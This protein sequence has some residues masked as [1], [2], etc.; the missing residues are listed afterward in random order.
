MLLI[1]EPERQ[2]RRDYIRELRAI[3]ASQPQYYISDAERAEMQ[4]RKLE[5]EALAARERMRRKEFI[6]SARARLA[7]YF[8]LESKRAEMRA[9]VERRRIARENREVRAWVRRKVYEDGLRYSQ[10]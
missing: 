6:Q 3:I 4:K 7:K 9:R 8:A 10:R 5:R 2:R 1:S